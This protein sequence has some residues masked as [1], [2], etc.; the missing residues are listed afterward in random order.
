MRELRA[1]RSH[2]DHSDKDTSPSEVVQ[3]GPAEGNLQIGEKVFNTGCKSLSRGGRNSVM[4]RVVGDDS[5]G[6][7]EAAA[8]WGGTVEAVIHRQQPNHRINEPFYLPR[9]ISVAAACSLSPADSPW[10]GILLV[11]IRGEDDALDAGKLFEVWQPL[12]AIL[13]LPSS[14]SR[15]KRST[16]NIQWR[17]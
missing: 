10:D 17:Q 13:A 4:F 7:A 1:S 14:L 6:W 12:I 5:F 16:Y 2:E 9:S 8:L 11:T 15:S 3:V